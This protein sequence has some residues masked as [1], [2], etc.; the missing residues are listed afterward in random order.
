MLIKLH[1]SLLLTSAYR[2]AVVFVSGVARTGVVALE[3]P[4]A[5]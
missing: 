2:S 1:Y 3:Y 4:M 5:A